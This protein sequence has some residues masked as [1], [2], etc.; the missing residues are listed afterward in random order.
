[1]KCPKCLKQAKYIGNQ[2]VSC[3][4]KG[5]LVLLG[6]VKLFDCPEHGSFVSAHDRLK[7]ERMLSNETDQSL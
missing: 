2:E 1:M 6:Y 4:R 5:K 7:L 3:N